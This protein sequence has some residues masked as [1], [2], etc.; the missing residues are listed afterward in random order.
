MVL[1]A[2]SYFR[3]K[4]TYL[5]ISSGYGSLSLTIHCL[6]FATYDARSASAWR[7]V[8]LAHAKRMRVKA[9]PE[10]PPRHSPP[11]HHDRTASCHR[12]AV[13]TL[14]S[15][16]QTMLCAYQALPPKRAGRPM[17][18]GCHVRPEPASAD[19]FLRHR[20]IGT[21]EDIGCGKILRRRRGAPE[22]PR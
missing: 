17:I 19:A 4:P 8:S 14:F 2:C 9:S 20:Q 12:L 7:Q 15:W 18:R 10:A 3:V 5:A 21:R 1:F 22:R 13:T 16:M 11:S 6:I